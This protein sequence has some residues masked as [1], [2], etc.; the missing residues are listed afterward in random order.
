[1][2]QVMFETDCRTTYHSGSPGAQT[3]CKRLPKTLCGGSN[4]DFVTEEERC[5]NKTVD[6]VLEVPRE[7]CDISPNTGVGKIIGSACAVCGVLVIALPIPIIVN[8]FAEFYNQ[9]VRKEK[10]V[11]RKEALERAKKEGSIVAF[12]NVNLRD[13]FIKSMDLVDVIV[14]T[15]NVSPNYLFLYTILRLIVKDFRIIS[16]YVDN[17]IFCLFE[18]NY[19][20]LIMIS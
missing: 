6:R 13:A 9:Q 16:L 8:N 3:M 2:L 15:G 18:R 4:C 5:H 11:K 10:A 19:V 14:D 20:K 7:S 17:E 1:M 12:H